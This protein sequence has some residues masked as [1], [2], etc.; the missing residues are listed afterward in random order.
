MK[1]LH[2]LHFWPLWVL[3]EVGGFILSDVGGNCTRK[4]RVPEG[5]LSS[6]RQFLCLIE[7]GPSAKVSS[8]TKFKKKK[9]LSHQGRGQVQKEGVPV[10]SP[11]AWPFLQALLTSTFYLRQIIVPCLFNKLIRVE[12]ILYTTCW[13][14]RVRMKCVKLLT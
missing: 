11:A 9:I 4:A 10:S 3:V 8:G 7:F 13:I 1:L 14:L 2:I 6:Q 12:G 5:S